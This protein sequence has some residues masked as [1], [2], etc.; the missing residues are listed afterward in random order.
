MG[1][2]LVVLF[3]L[4]AHSSVG[5]AHGQTADAASSVPQADPDITAAR[6]SG[7][8]VTIDLAGRQMILKT[9]AGS[10]VV[11]ALDDR[12]AYLHVP[13]GEVTLEKAVS[14]SPASIGVGDRVI[15]R[16]KVS[17]DKKSVAARQVIVMTKADLALKGE[18]EREEWRRHGIAGRIIEVR[19]AE[20]EV[21]AVLRS[22]AGE[23]RIVLGV[24]E[25][26]VL[27]RFVAGTVKYSDARPSSFEELKIG[28]HIRA[29]GERSSDGSRYTPEEIISGSFRMVGGPLKAVNAAAGELT[30]DNLE[31]GRPV[32]ITVTKDS[33]LRRVPPDLVSLIAQRKAQDDAATAGG[34]RP[35]QS[36][37]SA[38]EGQ[39]NDD[40]QDLI[41]RLPQ[42]PL[43]ELKVGETIVVS[44]TAGPDPAQ[45]TGII[46][47]AGLDSLLKPAKAARNTLKSTSAGSSLGLPSGVLDGGTS[48]P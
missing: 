41:E 23:Q 27:R 4:L 44:S 19:P 13:P 1:K 47:A 12:T 39:A 16:G 22:G 8:V 38:P 43:S 24:S 33:M 42:L 37:R 32:T 10:V 29:L 34:T 20:R 46:V 30:I 36:V 31:D 3:L 35:T 15:A 2:W 28:D 21:V 6:V 48:G 5:V 11:G 14:I 7:E 25:K 17:Q 26:V 18:R 40:I 9:V 45:V